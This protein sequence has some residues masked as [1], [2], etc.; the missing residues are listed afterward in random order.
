MVF[1]EVFATPKT[2]TNVFYGLFDTPKCQTLV[3]YEVLPTP[4]CETI[5][6]Y[7]VLTTPE[8]RMRSPPRL[9]SKW[10][11]LHKIMNRKCLVWN[12]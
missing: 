4:R 12:A 2:E 10:P 5:V 8:A 11:S 7:E 6:F 3:F 1:Y 9:A